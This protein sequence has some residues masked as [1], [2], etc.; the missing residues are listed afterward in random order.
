MIVGNIDMSIMFTEYRYKSYVVL[1]GSKLKVVEE[2]VEKKYLQSLEY[3]NHPLDVS[4]IEWMISFPSSFFPMK[5]E[6]S[7]NKIKLCKHP[8]GIYLSNY[9]H[10]SWEK[11]RDVHRLNF[12]TVWAVV[13]WTSIKRTGIFLI[14]K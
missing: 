10:C 5:L 2:T 14:Q 6:N 1:S 4:W 9:N 13:V 3:A 8:G 11:S 7:T 12:T